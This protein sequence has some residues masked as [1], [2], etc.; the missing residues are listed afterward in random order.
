[1]SQ[2]PGEVVTFEGEEAIATLPEGQRVT[3]KLPDVFGKLEPRA[4]PSCRTA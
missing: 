1:M 4:A 2:S 3:A